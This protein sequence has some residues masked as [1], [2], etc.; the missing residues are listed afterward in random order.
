MKVKQRLQ[1][2]ILSIS[3]VSFFIFIFLFLLVGRE[4]NEFDSNNPNPS[5]S[6]K[7]TNEEISFFIDKN[8][9]NIKDNEE[10]DCSQCAT[11]QILIETNSGNRRE[12]VKK[13]ISDDAILPAE[14]TDIVS[15]WGYLPD[16]K[17]IVPLYTFSSEL[18]GQDISIPV[19]ESTYMLIAENANING[20]SANELSEK[21]YQIDFEFGTLVP[22][23]NSFVNSDKPVWYL[24]YPDLDEKGDYYLASGTVRTLGESKS[25]SSSYWHFLEDYKEIENIDHYMLLIPTN[26]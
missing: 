11:K 5:G 21:N 6:L 13:V 16:D 1:L 15:L 12:I 8:K 17:L 9:N 19:I 26:N 23:L 10:E 2:L 18:R 22:A 24:F 14:S 3:I 4:Q 25:T 7:V 20:I